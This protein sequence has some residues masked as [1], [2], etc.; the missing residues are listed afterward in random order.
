MQPSLLP[1]K[2]INVPEHRMTYRSEGMAHEPSLRVYTVIR[3]MLYILAKEPSQ[4][5]SASS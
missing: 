2:G 3:R 4:P 5:P 1:R